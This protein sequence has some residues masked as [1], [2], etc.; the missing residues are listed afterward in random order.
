MDS[1]MDVYSTALILSYSWEEIPPPSKAV[2][3]KAY[4]CVFLIYHT[5][6]NALHMYRHGQVFFFF[7]FFPFPLSSSS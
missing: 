4:F 5:F 2:E 6:R 3:R 7:F 1:S